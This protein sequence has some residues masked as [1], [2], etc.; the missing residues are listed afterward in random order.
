MPKDQNSSNIEYDQVDVTVSI[1]DQIKEENTVVEC[2]ENLSAIIPNIKV[3]TDKELTDF[4]ED[5]GGY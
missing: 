3:V 1:T 4:L 5:D 2:L